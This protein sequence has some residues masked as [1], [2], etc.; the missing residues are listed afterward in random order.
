MSL[1]LIS[2]C[3]EI[4]QKSIDRT[5]ADPW[6]LPIDQIS[7]GGDRYVCNEYL[8]SG[9]CYPSD[10]IPAGSYEVI[11]PDKP[12]EHPYDGP[13]CT[14]SGYLT[15]AM[16]GY[17]C[18]VEHHIDDKWVEW[19]CY[20]DG[21]VGECGDGE[22]DPDNP[23]DCEPPGQDND[24]DCYQ[25]VQEMCDSDGKLLGRDEYGQCGSQCICQYD[26][27]DI[28]YGCNV[29]Q[30]PADCDATGF[31]EFTDCSDYLGADWEG[32]LICDLDTCGIDD[33]ACVYEGTSCTPGTTQNCPLQLGVCS[34]STETCNAQGE[35]P[36]CTASDYGSDYEVTEITCDGVADNDCDGDIDGVDCDCLVGYTNCDGECVNIMEDEDHCG[37]CFNPCDPYYECMGGWCELVCVDSDGDTFNVNEEECGPM[38]CDDSDSSIYPGAEEICDD[39]IDQDCDGEDCYEG[40]EY[41]YD[42]VDNDGNGDIDCQDSVCQDNNFCLDYPRYICKNYDSWG[43]EQVYIVDMPFPSVDS[44]P[45][46]VDLGVY[47]NGEAEPRQAGDGHVEGKTWIELLDVSANE[48]GRCYGCYWHHCTERIGDEWGPELDI[49]QYFISGK[50]RHWKD[51]NNNWNGCDHS[52]GYDECSGCS[53]DPDGGGYRIWSEWDLECSGSDSNHVCVTDESDPVVPYFSSGQQA[54]H[55]VQGNY[56]S[57]LEVSCHNK[58]YPVDWT[59]SSATCDEHPDDYASRCSYRSIC[60]EE[61]PAPLQDGG[62]WNAFV[63]FFTGLF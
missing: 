57:G 29:A 63:N 30:C 3:E 11:C 4:P 13:L 15:C 51:E 45:P 14:V 12:D 28:E 6:G 41:C 17:E 5:V 50:T 58:G 7:H 26:N 9:G 33:S 40:I 34:G 53:A 24:D 47:V 25:E 55:L 23:V 32:D 61:P 49:S 35:W 8:N 44:L 42:G 37:E 1:F 62:F 52:C 39:G 48:C 56:C 46:D 19:G 43:C 38:D 10:Y 60:V 20:C 16:N 22:V 2:S 27:F 36:G 54:C 18:S 21:Y 59:E 31:G